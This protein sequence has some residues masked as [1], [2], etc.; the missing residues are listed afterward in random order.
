MTGDNSTENTMKEA[1]KSLMSAAWSAPE[2]LIMLSL[3][4]VAVVWAT[5]TGTLPGGGVHFIGD[6]VEGVFWGGLYAILGMVYSH[7]SLKEG[8]LTGGSG[9]NLDLASF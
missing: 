2:S 3:L 1:A 8:D 5:H 4:I 9:T 7:V 6:I